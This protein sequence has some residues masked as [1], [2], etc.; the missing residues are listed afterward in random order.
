M[1]GKLRKM[2]YVF[3]EAFQLMNPLC[4]SVGALRRER[5]CGPVEVLASFQ[6]DVCLHSAITSYVLP[7]SRMLREPRHPEY[8][9]AASV[10]EDPFKLARGACVRL[11]P[12]STK[13]SSIN[14]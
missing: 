4:I 14:T 8:C 10:A 1:A 6:Q 5:K 11:Q 2:L 12:W 13:T 7:Y 3:C 9:C